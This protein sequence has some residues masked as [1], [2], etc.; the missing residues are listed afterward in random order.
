MVS[1]TRS[2]TR[3]LLEFVPHAVVLLDGNRIV[4]LNRAAAELLGDRE[5][6]SWIGTEFTPRLRS[7]RLPQFGELQYAGFGSDQLQRADGSFADVQLETHPFDSRRHHLTRVF[8][9]GTSMEA[10]LR[11]E[12]RRL[13][14]LRM[15][16]M[17]RLAGG[18][19]HDFNNL[20][21]AV[22]AHSEF[23]RA[24]VTAGGVLARHLDQILV[25][26]DRAADLTRKLLSFSRSSL[27]SVRVLD[28]RSLLQGLT[29][30]MTRLLG[31]QIDLQVRLGRTPCSLHADPQQ[32]ER[33][34]THLVLNARDAMSNGGSLVIAIRQVRVGAVLAKLHGAIRPGNYVQLVVRDTGVGM[35]EDVQGRI[36]E[37]F[38]T[39]KQL[40][41]GAGL[42]LATCYGIIKQLEGYVTTLS[43][44]GSGTTFLIYL[45]ACTEQPPAESPA[46]ER[47]GPHGT[48]T[49]LLVEDDT[50]VR[51]VTAKALACFGYD[52]LT[53]EHGEQ[54]LT[55]AGD[56]PGRIDALV[57]DIVMP[58]LGG[59]ELATR[60]RLQFP[61]LKVLYISGYTHSALEARDLKKPGTAF[62]HKPFAPT[63]LGA[64][65]RELLGRG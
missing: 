65:L 26:A 14:E 5:S 58:R 3:S 52:V 39:T 10:T 30:L 27:G 25:A 28:L 49:I 60:L 24:E 33:M 4:Y 35:C 64:E 8:L 16:S 13:Q 63:D 9:R 32:L 51:E 61:Y 45:P 29:D 2:V 21:T 23:A 43:R 18:I 15:E 54:G 38:F 55:V 22:V 56:H 59:R 40:G 46:L 53:A 42:G 7:G 50:L 41:E 44:P 57:T 1:V 34:L 12:T 47:P 31:D 62:L 11:S 37:P 36:F 20:L 48:G 19:A 6:G 17:G